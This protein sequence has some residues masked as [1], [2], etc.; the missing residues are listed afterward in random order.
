[1]LCNALQDLQIV[2]ISNVR[3]TVFASFRFII[4]VVIVRT[5]DLNMLG[6]NDNKELF[7]YYRVCTANYLIVRMDF[8]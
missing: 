4:S 1:M 6:S 2:C 7:V 3:Q 8:I 5:C